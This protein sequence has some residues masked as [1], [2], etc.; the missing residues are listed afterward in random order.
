MQGWG[1]AAAGSD[2]LALRP[3][4]C[5]LGQGQGFR[6]RDFPRAL[7]LCPSSPH[8]GVMLKGKENRCC[9]QGLREA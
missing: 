3:L 8:S 4:V 9:W 6:S 1:R 5:V 2:S 7:S